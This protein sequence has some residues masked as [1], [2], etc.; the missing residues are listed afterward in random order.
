MKPEFSQRIFE[1][2]SN[3]KLR[4]NPSIGSPVVPCRQTDGRTERYYEVNSRFSEFRKQTTGTNSYKG[5]IS[6]LS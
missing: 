6:L 4:E 5:Y 2:Y 1:K 3:I